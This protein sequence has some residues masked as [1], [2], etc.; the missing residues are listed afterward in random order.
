[1][2]GNRR[3]RILREFFQTLAAEAPATV[4]RQRRRRRHGERDQ[5]IQVE[6]KAKRSDRSSRRIAEREQAIEAQVSL[7]PGKMASVLGR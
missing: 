1:M 6:A 2:P 5:S 3:S 7:M 4:P